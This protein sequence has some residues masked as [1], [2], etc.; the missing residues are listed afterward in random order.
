[1]VCFLNGK[2]GQRDTSLPADPVP[3]NTVQFPGMR[4]GILLAKR[5]LVRFHEQFAFLPHMQTLAKF[6]GLGR[7]RINKDWR[8]AGSAQA[9][10]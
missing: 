4:K 2:S 7:R 6:I 9:V 8:R 3:H 1:M 10:E 5:R